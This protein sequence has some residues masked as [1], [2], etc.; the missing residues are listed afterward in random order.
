MTWHEFKRS[1]FDDKEQ[2]SVS[3]C[4]IFEEESEKEMRKESHYRV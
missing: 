2:V 3:T 1:F 4:A